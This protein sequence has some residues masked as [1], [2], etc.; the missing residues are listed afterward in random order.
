MTALQVE[1]HT[2][3]QGCERA[4][5]VCRRRSANENPFLTL[6]WLKLWWAHFGSGRSLHL[7]LVKEKNATVGFVPLYRID[8]SVPGFAEYRFLGH[9]LSNYLDVVCLPDHE[10]RVI[11]AIFAALQDRP[12]ASLLCLH[13]INDRFSRSW[14]VLQAGLREHAARGGY[15]SVFKL[16]PCPA[17]SLR[18]TFDE[19]LNRQRDR[20]SRYKLRRSERK[21]ADLGRWT[22][23]E[24]RDRGEL[25]GLLAELERLHGERFSETVNPLFSGRLREFMVAALTDLLGSSLSLSLAEVDGV[26]VSYLIGLR[27]GDVFVDYAP[28][29][30]PAFASF[31]LGN[32]H[33]MKVI[34]QKMQEGFRTFDFSK[35]EAPYKRWW[36]DHETANYAFR[37]GFHLSRAGFWYARA[38][39]RLT[40]A[41]V[42]MRSRGYNTVA[43]R[44]WATMRTA[45]SARRRAV[46]IEETASPPETW[47]EAAPWSYERIRNLPAAVRRTV[48]NQ[49]ARFDVGRVRIAVQEDRRLVMI[50]PD[51]GDRVSLVHY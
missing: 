19:F 10:A 39:N 49:C 16:Y 38:A 3:F 14:A 6:D 40:G 18:G 7:L 15:A 20:K 36:S 21:L 8:R 41:I 34:E 47:P 1:V 37:F 46:R 35:G 48:V 29:F 51:E 43:K 32:V 22:F 13:D 24:V 9:G 45:G 5:E 42:G 30:D 11:A 33:L 25:P 26:L 23:R 28:G 12:E 50:K 2:T 31:S 27:M 4:L 44:W 17:A